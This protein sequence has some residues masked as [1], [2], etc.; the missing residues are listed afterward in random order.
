MSKSRTRL[1]SIVRPVE[2]VFA[3][4]TES[5]HLDNWFAEDVK[6]EPRLDGCFAFEGLDGYS[7]G[8]ILAF[9]PPNSIQFTL[10]ANGA[11]SIAA[12]A[13]KPDADGTGVTLTLTVEEDNHEAVG[14]A[15]D[16]VCLTLYNVRAYLEVGR[17]AW[18][19]ETTP[20]N[21]VS[22]SIQVHA[23]P[24]DAFA[25]LI[26]PDKLKKWLSGDSSVDVAK[27]EYSYGWT[28]EEDGEQVP[29]GPAKIV[30]MEPEKRLVHDWYYPDDGSS[31]VE[32]TVEGEGGTTTVRLTHTGL[33]PDHAMGYLRGWSV[34]LYELQ[35][36]LEGATIATEPG[37][38]VAD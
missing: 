9:D 25:A 20:S 34:I 30:E 22:A 31:Q 3:A 12:F 33:E 4:L 10:T 21:E 26:D 6:I 38:S 29:A 27:G 17:L 5:S 37:D 18:Q 28:A 11:Q 14:L 24:G 8:E 23:T 15:S 16:W 7:S 13:L 35:A 19:A 2:D 1:L 32:W 36:Y